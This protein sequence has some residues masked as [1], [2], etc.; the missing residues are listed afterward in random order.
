MNYEFYVT[1][2]NIRQQKTPR[3]GYVST[4]WLCSPALTANNNSHER[5]DE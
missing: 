1:G 4:I 3:Q 5:A 2:K